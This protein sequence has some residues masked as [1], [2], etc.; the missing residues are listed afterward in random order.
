MQ[1]TF[2]ATNAQISTFDYHETVFTQMLKTFSAV[3]P[4][5]KGVVLSVL[6]Q[7]VANIA[8]AICRKMGIKHQVIVQENQNVSNMETSSD[9]G[10]T[11]NLR[12]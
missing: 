11:P 9:S 6:N 10:N 2:T 1:A 8:T 3:Y 12:C 5:D 4:K 7:D